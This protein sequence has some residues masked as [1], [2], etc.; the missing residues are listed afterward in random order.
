MFSFTWYFLRM[1][2]TGSTLAGLLEIKWTWAWVSQGIQHWVCPGRLARTVAGTGQGV[3]GAL[4]IDVAW[5][6]YWKVNLVWASSVMARA[7]L[8]QPWWDC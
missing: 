5:K 3:L 8:V 7:E 4:C 2:F 1:L 6:D